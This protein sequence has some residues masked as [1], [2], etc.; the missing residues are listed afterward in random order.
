MDVLS[1]VDR[2]LPRCKDGVVAASV[3]CFVLVVVLE[4]FVI[5]CFISFPFPVSRPVHCI[6]SRPPLDHTVVTLIKLLYKV[7]CGVDFLP[8][9][10]HRPRLSDSHARSTGSEKT[11][12]TV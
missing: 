8:S 10:F 7:V 11:I 2:T 9:G 6:T 1:S 12:F 5:L 4:E 3:K